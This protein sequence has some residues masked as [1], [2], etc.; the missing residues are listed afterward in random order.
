MVELAA[1]PDGA[2]VSGEQIASVQ[3]IPARFLENI[4][5]ELRHHGLVRTAPGDDQSFQLTE[6]AADVTLAEVI[7]AV[8]GPVARVHGEQ[9]ESLE[10]GGGAAAL[11]Q[12]WVALGA[13]VRRVLESVTLADVVSGEL[14]GPVIGLSRDTGDRQGA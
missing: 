11:R 4:L 13:N 14:P 12:V 2:P 1:A 6:P 8:D 10:Y 9:P 3:R 5:A 7:E